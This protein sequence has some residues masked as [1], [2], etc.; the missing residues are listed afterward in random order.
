MPND[1]QTARYDG[2]IRRV[3]GL[4]G[5][6]SKVTETLSE[7]FP[8]VD[9]ENLPAELLFLAG[10]RTGYR[11]INISATPGQTSRGQLINP[12]GS[13]LIVSVTDVWLE[14]TSIQQ[15]NYTTESV[16]FTPIFPGRKRD[17]RTGAI[18]DTG[19]VVALASTGNTVRRGSLTLLGNVTFHHHASNNDLFVLAPGTAIEYG[20]ELDN[21]NLALTFFWR[22]RAALSSELNF[23]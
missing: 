14:M 13:G 22:E 23:P 6:G 15:V 21:L 3:G 18:E 8:M 12:L 10:W 7:L 17:T 5:G 11:A 16:L 20:T 4:L 9:V 19:A 2:L 1:L